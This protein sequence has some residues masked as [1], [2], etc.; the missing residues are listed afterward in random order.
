[1]NQYTEMNPNP[2]VQYLNKPSVEFTKEDIIRYVEDHDISMVNFR[3][4]GWDGRLKTLNFVVN[5]KQHL[6]SILSYGE[7]VD[8]SSLFSFIEAGSSD[9][10]VI[11]RYKTAFLNPFSE[12]PQ[13]DI[14]CS[15]YNM[16]GEPL[17]SSPEYILRRAHEVLIEKTG[18]QLEAMGELE[19]YIISE[20]EELFQATDQKGYHEAEPFSK[21]GDFRKEAMLAIAQAG[22]L[23]KYGHSEV[24]N[25]IVGNLEYE[26]NEIEFA[27]TAIE[28]AADQLIIAK[29]ILRTLAYQYGVTVTFAPKIT[30]G[31][32][33]SGLHIHC[34]LMKDGKSQMVE[35]GQLSEVAKKAIAGFLDLAPSITAFGNLNPMSYFRLVPH[36][37]A[38]TNICWGDRNRSVLVR[39]PL[40]WTGKLDMAEDANPLQR[41]IKTEPLD[42][43][44]VELRS[45]DGSADV[46]T[47]LAA[48]TIAARHGLEMKNA[49][50]FAEKTYVDVNIFNDENKKRLAELNHLPSSCWESA[51]ALEKQKSI[52]ME[53]GIITEGTLDGIIAYHKTYNDQNL[54]EEIKDKPEVLLK[55]VTK[56]FHCG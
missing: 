56:F 4:C 20:K 24:G 41:N 11:P 19:Y 13:L 43:Q 45:P 38:P 34:R 3:Y 14:L 40:G 18:Y 39:V 30:T 15:Y 1:M 21:W 2:L 37:E 29:W 31:K 52:Y 16:D 23:I 51:H 55:L 49:L 22:G 5:S 8:G 26:Q 47:L 36:Q 25:F 27:P 17:A 44:T 10:Y 7:R 50:S 9:L 42:R 53:N 54:R 32:A 35:N 12:Q 46:Y 6:D 33:G 48:I 28:D